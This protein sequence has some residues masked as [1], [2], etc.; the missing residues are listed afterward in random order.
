M[1]FFGFGYRVYSA[2][3]GKRV[4]VLDTSTATSEQALLDVYDDIIQ[5]MA[6]SVET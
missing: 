6:K 5:V 4:I 2:H 3:I 1:F